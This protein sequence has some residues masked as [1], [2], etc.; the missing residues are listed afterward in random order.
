MERKVDYGKLV[1]YTFWSIIGS[2]ALLTA[3]VYSTWS[4][5]KF[6]GTILFQFSIAIWVYIVPIISTIVVLGM[7]CCLYEEEFSMIEDEE[8]D[9]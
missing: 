5:A 6:N 7:L 2:I 1:F 3:P 8:G 9:K 4:G